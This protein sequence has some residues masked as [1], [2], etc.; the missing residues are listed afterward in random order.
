MRIVNN[1]KKIFLT[2]A[3]ILFLFPLF[4]LAQTNLNRVVMSAGSGE[5]VS[6]QDDISNWSRADFVGPSHPRGL[7]RCNGPECGFNDFMEMIMRVTTYLIGFAIATVSITI[8]YAGFIYMTAGG[9]SGKISKAH[10]MFKKAAV[11]FIIVLSAFLIVRL[12]ITTTG[13]DQKG[14]LNVDLTDR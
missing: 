14:Q 2:S 9:D 8:A 1:I 5:Q 4:T 6:F 3:F 11:G 10:E 7:V 12:I 13:A